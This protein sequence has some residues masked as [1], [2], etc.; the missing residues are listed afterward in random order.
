MQLETFTYVVSICS[1]ITAIWALAVMLV[2]PLRNRFFDFTSIREGQKCLLRSSMLRT[3]YNHLD[4]EKIHQFE[5]ENFMYDYAAYKAL[6]GNSFI[7]HVKNEV[8]TWSVVP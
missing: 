3:Y 4:D 6:G 8:E 7:E 2:K 1:G 5:Y